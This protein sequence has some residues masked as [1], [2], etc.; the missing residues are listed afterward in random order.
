MTDDAY[1]PTCIKLH[2]FESPKMPSK[3]AFEIYL[4]KASMLFKTDSE[5]DEDAISSDQL[6]KTPESELDRIAPPPAASPFM[7]VL[8]DSL[9]DWLSNATP[10]RTLKVIV[11]PPCDESGTIKS[12]AEANA[13]EC[14]VPPTHHDI[15]TGEAIVPDIQSGFPLVIPRLEAW[16]IRSYHGLNLMR[17]LLDAITNSKRK[18]V[19]GCNIFAWEFL[20]KAVNAAAY[21]PD[22]LTF[23]ALDHDQL[24]DWFYTLHHEAETQPVRLRYQHSA[25]AVFKEDKAAEDTNYFKILA[26]TSLGIPWVA[27]HLWRNNLLTQHEN[28]EEEKD[29]DKEEQVDIAQEQRVVEDE[30]EGQETL[31]VAALQE[32]SLPKTEN[33]SSLFVLQAILIHNEISSEHLAKVLPDLRPLTAVPLLKRADVI[34]EHNGVL[35]CKPQAYPAIRAGLAASGFPLGVL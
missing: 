13:L 35:R 15:L 18:V 20:K 34:T 19:V 30:S 9:S 26:A 6:Y 17:A 8:D 11:L 23:Q 32:L 27:W 7:Q 12:W 21:L 29:K 1:L 4:S 2:D 25:E 24:R 14:L 16:M 5:A 10:N 22:P 31:W 3:R 33:D 28:E